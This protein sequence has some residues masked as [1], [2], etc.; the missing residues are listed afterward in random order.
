MEAI[1]HMVE[2]WLARHHLTRSY[3]VTDRGANMV[4]VV[5]E[6]GFVGN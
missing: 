3:M 5:H 2:G 6:G 1:N 4:K